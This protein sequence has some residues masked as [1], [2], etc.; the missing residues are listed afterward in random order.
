MITRA[1]TIV[2]ADANETESQLHDRM[3][4]TVGLADVG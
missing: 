1:S 3:L 4:A 2:T